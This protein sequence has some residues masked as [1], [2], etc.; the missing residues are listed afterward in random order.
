MGAMSGFAFGTGLTVLLLG[1]VALVALVLLPFAL[2][3]IRRLLR[4]LL[5]EQ[6]RTNEL[7]EELAARDRPPVPVLDVNSALPLPDERIEPS[8][9]DTGG[10]RQ[11]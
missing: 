8:F 6:E 5:A 1:L 3:G 11:R 7:L 2:F 9:L 4:A 10:R